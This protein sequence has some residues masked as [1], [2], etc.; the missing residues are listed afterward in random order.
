MLGR[1][2]TLH[3]RSGQKVVGRKHGSAELHTPDELPEERFA[4]LSRLGNLRRIEGDPASAEAFLSDALALAESAFPH[5]RLRVASAL[6]ALG[7]LY[8]DLA[9]FDDA[10]AFYERALSLVDAA[11]ESHDVA[12]VYHNLGGIEHAR[13]N[14]AAGEPFARKGLEIR[15]RLSDRD[16]VAL[17]TDMVALAAILDGQRKF[18]EAEALYVDALRILDGDPESNAGEIA[19]ALNDLGAHY[20]QRDQIDRADDLLVRAAEL[21]ARTLGPRHPDVAVTLNNLAI[22]HKRRGDVARAASLYQDAVSIF[23]ESLGPDHPK[24]IACRRNLARCAEHGTAAGPDT[25]PRM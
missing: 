22:V 12:T 11:A 9:R 10:R 8:K 23:E 4:E 3:S 5:D 16:D 14:F 17:A 19:V 20:A 7:L 13:Q 6:N 24:A 21:K 2:F 15:R 18:E 1:P 25:A